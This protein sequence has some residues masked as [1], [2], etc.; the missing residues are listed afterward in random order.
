M[1]EETTKTSKTK[2]KQT[3]HV[4]PDDKG[5]PERQ[6]ELDQEQLTDVSGGLSL[7]ITGDTSEK[8]R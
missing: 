4:E 7:E 6:G 3:G 2:E 1:G 8:P 5:K